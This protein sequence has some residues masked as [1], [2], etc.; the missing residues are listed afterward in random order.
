MKKTFICPFC[1]MKLFQDEAAAGRSVQCPKCGRF[2]QLTLST[3]ENDISPDSNSS[4][5]KKQCSNSNKSFFFDQ[6]PDSSA[7]PE[8]VANPLK[9]KNDGEQK[10]DP[11]SNSQNGPIFVRE[12]VVV[13]PLLKKKPGEL[14]DQSSP[15]ADQYGNVENPMAKIRAARREAKKNKKL[16]SIEVEEM[17]A[18]LLAEEEKERRQRE[19]ALSSDNSESKTSVV[20]DP[21]NNPLTPGITIYHSPAPKI[22][23]AEISEDGETYD[24]KD[25]DSG[26][27]VALEKN[28]AALNDSSRPRSASPPQGIALLFSRREFIHPQRNKL[29]QLQGDCKNRFW[30]FIC[31]VAF[32]AIVQTVLAFLPAEQM[33]ELEKL[34]PKEQIFR[35]LCYFGNSVICLT[36]IFFGLKYIELLKKLLGFTGMFTALI[37]TL[38]PLF[39]LVI[40]YLVFQKAGAADV[41]RYSS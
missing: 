15:I 21:E 23:N 36:G 39:G 4:V 14:P 35:Y 32:I 30:I 34:V 37:L 28:A 5:E 1:Q 2:F 18:P 20:F 8:Y 7:P 13:N 38:V 40:I 24:F 26:D 10:S 19:P 29:L 6:N 3:D 41:S 31:A 12:G 9:R 25:I 16:S 27:L 33:A 11:V 17:I 22:K